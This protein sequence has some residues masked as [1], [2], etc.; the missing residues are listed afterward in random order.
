LICF[1]LREKRADVSLHPFSEN[2]FSNGG[3]AILSGG[4]L[5]NL[6]DGERSE[7]LRISLELV[8]ELLSD[9]VARLSEESAIVVNINEVSK[10][11]GFGFNELS[12][13]LEKR[14]HGFIRDVQRNLFCVE[15]SDPEEEVKAFYRNYF[16]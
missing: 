8:E 15:F 10:V 5:K 2:V 4:S 16:E 13:A 7:E 3:I 14:F 11:E 6:D 12:N 9:I 1:N